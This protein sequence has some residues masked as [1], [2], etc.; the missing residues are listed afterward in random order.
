MSPPKPFT[1]NVPQDKIDRLK[2]K[3]ALAEFP[4]ELE[5][6]EWSLGCP[7]SEIKSLTKAWQDFDWRAA[8]KKLNESPQFHTDIEVDKFGT[9]DIHF[10]HQKAES[11]DAIPLLF[12]HGWPGSFIEVLKLLPLLTK[13]SSSNEISFHVVAPSLPNY[14]FSS[15]VSQ[16]GFALAQYAETC[17]KLMLQLGYN[18]YVTQAGDWGWW[19]TR[20]IGRL[21]P[22]SCLASHFNMVLANSPD[23][24][25]SPTNFDPELYTDEEKAGLERTQ[26]F[27]KEGMG[28]NLEQSTKPQT[29][30][31]ALKDSPVALLAWIYDKLHDWTDN[32]PWDVD[33]TLTWISIYQFSRAGPGAPQRIYYEVMHT[34]TDGPDPNK[35]CTYDSLREYNAKVPI[36]LT[37][38]PRDLFI[39]P[40]SW[41]ETL[42]PVNFDKRNKQGGHFY[43]HEQ[44]ELLA[45]DLK[46]MFRKDGDTYKSISEKLKEE[47]ADLEFQRSTIAAAVSAQGA[48]L[49]IAP[50]SPNSSWHLEFYG[51]SLKCVDLDGARRKRVLDNIADYYSHAT[52]DYVCTD[53]RCLYVSW[54]QDLPFVNQSSNYSYNS[55]S[56]SSAEGNA[57][58]GIA[59]LPDMVHVDNTCEDFPSSR[60]ASGGN[61]NVSLDNLENPFGEFGAGAAT[62]QC[63]FFNSSYNVDFEYVN[64]KQSITIDAPVKGSDQPFKT[65]T[66][67]QQVQVNATNHN[68]TDSSNLAYDIGGRC[69]ST[70]SGPFPVPCEYDPAQ[71]RIISYQGIMEAFA[72]LLAGNVT[73]PRIGPLVK[74]TRLL[75]TALLNTKELAFLNDQNSYYLEGFGNGED[76]QQALAAAGVAVSGIAQGDNSTMNHSLG[77]TLEEMFRNY[78]VSLLSSE[79]L[80]PNGSQEGVPQ[81]NVTTLDYQTIYTYSSDK[82]WL[83]YG[84]AIFL[85]AI[86]VAQGLFVIYSNG[87]SYSNNFSTVMRSTWSAELNVDFRQAGTDCRDPLPDFLAKATVEFPATMRKAQSTDRRWID[88]KSNIQTTYTRVA[89]APTDADGRDA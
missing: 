33:E 87:A 10:I 15:G 32:Y 44:P 86:A 55:A 39:V 8:E 4:D 47:E 46:T 43:A 74:T 78:T 75:S 9:L 69:I 51:P 59:T 58:I 79:L 42:G 48:I 66:S 23:S 13:G 40:S 73:M 5:A 53:Q 50:P 17:H 41:A 38:S 34:S 29:L 11:G 56:I 49:S 24:K 28:Y 54:Y 57:T 19:I 3:L 81:A 45:Q 27:E 64:G 77:S 52:V 31:Y 6:S 67:V 21:Y 12:V 88:D 35:I 70:E 61:Q 18:K 82:L 76:L 37:Q 7:L 1:I 60:G 65:F 30:A 63:Q 84:I 22:D 36:G 72:N 2:Q 62:V 80:R 26:W 83:A 85:T 89:D 14:G 20:S 16:R 71:L 25:E 68:Q